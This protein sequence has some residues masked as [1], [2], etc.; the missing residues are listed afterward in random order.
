MARLVRLVTSVAPLFGLSLVPDP[1]RPR[2]SRIEGLGTRLVWTRITS[3][4]RRFMKNQ[5]K[6]SLVDVALAQCGWH[7]LLFSIINVGRKVCSLLWPCHHESGFSR[8]SAC[9]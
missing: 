8:P 9:Q 6:V 2:P 1:P 4:L 7:K 5:A 3:S